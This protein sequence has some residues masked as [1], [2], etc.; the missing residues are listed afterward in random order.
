MP[1][2]T[3]L[4][5][6]VV[7]IVHEHL[8]GDA[9]I[10]RSAMLRNRLTGKLREVDVVLRSK[11][12][13]GYETVIGIEAAGRGRPAAAD[14]VEAMAGKHRNLPTDKVILVSEEGFSDQARALAIEENMV[15]I[16]PEVMEQDDPALQVLKSMQSLWPK[17]ISLTPIRAK[18]GVGIPGGEIEWVH[19]GHDTRVFAEDG[20]YLELVTLT[21]ELI[22]G[23]MRRIVDQIDLR[24]IAED[25]DAY[26]V[27]GVGPGLDHQ[28]RG[29]GA[30][31][32]C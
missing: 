5:Q 31:L 9:E 1:K 19:A 14:W 6:D 8:A 24:N 17:K 16:A 10:E 3:N 13:P 32:V 30:F 28:G 25:K 23:N 11:T 12:G 29:P 26:A 4:F 22:N 18:L 15:P 27:I 7:S 2:R 20:S 21:K